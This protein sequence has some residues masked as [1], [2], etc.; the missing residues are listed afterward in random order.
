M[1]GRLVFMQT[2][3]RT[4]VVAGYCLSNKYRESL[5]PHVRSSLRPQQLTFSRSQSL[6]TNV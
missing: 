3:Q 5:P 1:T 2:P 4:Q 6:H